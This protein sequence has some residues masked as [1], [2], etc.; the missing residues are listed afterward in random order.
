VDTYKRTI[1]PAKGDPFEVELRPLMAGDRADIQDAVRVELETES[2]DG[3]DT[4][5]VKINMGLS[6]ILTVARAVVRWT[7]PEL[8]SESTVRNLPPDVFDAIY[9]ETAWGYVPDEEKAADPSSSSSDSSETLAEE[10]SA[11]GS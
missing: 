4:A 11:G 7:R 8:V 5:E 3:G 2:E 10:P 9:A 6:Q 1:S